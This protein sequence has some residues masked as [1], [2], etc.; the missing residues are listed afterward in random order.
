VRKFIKLHPIWSALVVGAIWDVPQWLA[1]VWSLFSADPLAKV[2]SG[3]LQK[4]GLVMPHFS[5]YLI[6]TPLALFMFGVIMYEVRKRPLP[7]SPTIE[8]LE[9]KELHEQASQWISTWLSDK[10]PYIQRAV[11]FG[12]VVYD[13]YA[14][15][16]VDVIVFA[17]PMTDRKSARIGRKIKDEMR[18]DFNL[19]F[20]HPLHVQLF[21]ANEKDRFEQFLSRLG[22]YEEL[23][24]K[25]RQ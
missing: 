13:Q 15:S 1:S 11:L 19:R 2:I 3:K 14:T 4:E 22:K 8:Q 18:R 12:S 7:K 17:Q 6:T 25:G 23:P 9:D 24:L 21:D 5:P 20:G 16:D 10:N